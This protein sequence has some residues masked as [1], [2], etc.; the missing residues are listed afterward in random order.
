MDEILT[1]GEIA[2]RL[3]IAERTVYAMAASG[4]LPAF[5]LRGQWRMRASDYESWLDQVA[6]RGRSEPPAPPPP[7]TEPPAPPTLTEE[8]MVE[9]QPDLPISKLTER[10]S[11][12]DMHRRLIEA[13]GKRVL[14][15]G[16]VEAKPLEVDLGGS[17]PVK[18]RIYMYNATRPP[19][20]RPLGEHKVQLIVPGQSRSQRGNFDNN[21]GRMALLIGYAA[22]E[23]VFILWDAGLYSDFAWSRNV[24]VKAETIIE[25]TAGKLATQFRQLR[26]ADGRPALE[27]LIAA[28]AEKLSEAI[29]RRIQLT[30]DRLSE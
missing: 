18:A 2:M 17:L 26:P 10:V 28:P 27:T 30:R 15:T 25:A 3:K 6:R 22:E 14:A 24:Q 1:I 16:P 7:A 12:V 23:D 4:E 19:G 5:K 29:D 13:L 8:N 21:G 11:Q 20:G 9:A